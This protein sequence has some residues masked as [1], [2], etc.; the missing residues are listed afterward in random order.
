MLSALFASRDG[1]MPHSASQPAIVLSGEDGSP[2]LECWLYAGELHRENGP[3]IV[4][5][6]P[7]EKG[8]DELHYLANTVVTPQEQKRTQ[9]EE[10]RK[11]SR[12]SS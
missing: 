9:S 6:W 7:N 10:T 2:L 12:W 5:Y 1:T 4:R 8:M 11:L 3:A